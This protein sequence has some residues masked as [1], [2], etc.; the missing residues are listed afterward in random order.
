VTREAIGAHRA[1]GGAV[2]GL[3]ALVVALDLYAVVG[4]PDAHRPPRPGDRAVELRLPRIESGGALGPPLA[5]SELAGRVVV[6]EFWA[7]WCGPCRAS[8]PI[9]ERLARRR[10]ELAVVS[11]NTEGAERA[12]SARAIATELAPSAILVSDDG[13]VADRYG[14]FTLPH[15][16]VIDG[17]GRVVAVHRG[18]AGASHLERLVGDALARS[19]R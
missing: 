10:P 17:E 3:A 9:L 14:V 1:T 4:D 7:T 6:I 12:A 2:L 5:L 13:S 19:S 16:V 15:T 8:M 11:I 18:F